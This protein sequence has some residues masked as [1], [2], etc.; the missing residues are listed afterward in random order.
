MYF[1]FYQVHAPFSAPQPSVKKYEEKQKTIALTDDVRFREDMHAG[2]Q[3]KFRD[4]QDHPT[5]AAMVASMDQAVG[6]VLEAVK[7]KGLEDNT[8]V[9]FCSDN[10]GLS[11]SEG[12]PTAN[13]PLK[14][15]N[16]ARELLI[17]HIDQT[18]ALPQWLASA[19]D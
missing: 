5:Y 12:M 19:S 7:A 2:K 3:V 8:V 4:R 18:G 14:A 6:R 17:S 13:T 1:S 10:G 15:G 16:D 11:T 9:V